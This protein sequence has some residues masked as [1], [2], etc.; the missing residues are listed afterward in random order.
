MSNEELHHYDGDKKNNTEVLQKEKSR[1][2]SQVLIFGLVILFFLFAGFK[3]FINLSVL[4]N[5]YSSG[6][7][8]SELRTVL[9]SDFAYNIFKVVGKWGYLIFFLLLSV[10]VYFLKIRGNLK[11]IKECN[12]LMK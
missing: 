10:M 8:E 2:Q 1:A 5:T 6:I 9:K 7:P 11:M 3:V 4:E 12:T